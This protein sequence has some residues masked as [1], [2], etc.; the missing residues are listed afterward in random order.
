MMWA[1]ISIDGRTG[2]VLEPGGGR[3]GDST[4]KKYI[5]DIFHEHVIP[6]S[7]FIGDNFMLMQDNARCHSSRETTLFLNE[8]HIPTMNWPAMSPDLNPIEPLWD[9]LKRRVRARNPGPN[10]I[11]QLKADLIEEWEGIPQETIKKLIVSM[12]SRLISVI[13]GR[14]A[15]LNIK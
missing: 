4:S 12:K 3:E 5:R 11:D 7:G 8:V 1:G 10:N 14:G 13:K 9:E 2:L 6:Y 15:I